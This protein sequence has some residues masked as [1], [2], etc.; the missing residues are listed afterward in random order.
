MLALI[1]STLLLV[2][3]NC[4]QDG[5]VT[6]GGDKPTAK[7]YKVELVQSEGGTVTVFPNIPNDLMVEESKELTFTAKE[8]K[9]YKIGKWEITGGTSAGGGQD[10]AKTAKVTTSVLG[11]KRYG[12]FTT[13]LT[14][15]N[16]VEEDTIIVFSANPDSKYRGV[17]EWQLNNSVIQNKDNEGEVK[18]NYECKVTA[19]LN[20]KVKF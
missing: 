6:E 20:M 7:K 4:K 3:A 18:K 14:N 17:E 10:G 5:G 12:T 1:V 11:V 9:D 15:L 13:N 2:F 19:N 16:H 8:D